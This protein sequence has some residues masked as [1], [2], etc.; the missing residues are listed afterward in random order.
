MTTVVSESSR[1]WQAEVKWRRRCY[2]VKRELPKVESDETSAVD[3]GESPATQTVETFHVAC[4]C[5]VE[6]FQPGGA[7]ISFRVN[8][9]QGRSL[10]FTD[11]REQWTGTAGT[12][13]IWGTL[14]EQPAGKP[15]SLTPTAFLAE[16]ARLIGA[17]RAAEIVRGLMASNFFAPSNDS[18]QMWS[19]RRRGRVKRPPIP[20]GGRASVRAGTAARDSDEASS[21]QFRSALR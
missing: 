1:A 14:P 16:V 3:S 10:T 17:E 15:R 13:G 11:P 7:R 12:R 9:R 4:E 8:R 18:C 21:S 5:F 2:A 6:V 19:D 20:S